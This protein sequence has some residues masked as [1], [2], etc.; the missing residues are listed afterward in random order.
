MTSRP[1][2][3]PLNREEQKIIFE[4]LQNRYKISEPQ[5]QQFPIESYKP[6][7]QSE[8]N[9]LKSYKNILEE[10]GITSTKIQVENTIKENKT[11]ATIKQF[12]CSHTYTPVRASIMGLPIRYKICSKCGLVK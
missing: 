11:T 2:Q 10:R 4:G 9:F 8:E 5:V 6:E 1:T 12:Y 7:K 3:A